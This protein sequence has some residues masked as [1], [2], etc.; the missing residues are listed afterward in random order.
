MKNQIEISYGHGYEDG[1]IA[2]LNQ[3]EALAKTNC[4]VPVMIS[5]DKDYN[6]G[7]QTVLYDIDTLRWAMRHGGVKNYEV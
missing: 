2:A 4:R 7:I 1:Y 6:D 5:S 3:L